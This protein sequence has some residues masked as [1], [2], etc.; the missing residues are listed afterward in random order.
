MPKIIRTTD[1]D[2]RIITG[3]NG[4]IILDTTNATND[5][6]GTVVI[7]GDLEVNGGT[8][9][10]ESTI[11]SIEDNIILLSSGNTGAGLPISLDR[12]RSSG[13]EVERGSL[14]NARW[15]Y[16]DSENWILGGLTGIGA[17]LG[18]QGDIGSEIFLPIKTPGILADGTLYVATGDGVISVTGTNNYELKIWNYVGGVITPDIVTGSITIDDDNIPNAKAVKDAIDYSI[19]TITID[20]IIEDNSKIE[21]IDKNN[22]ISSILEVGSRTILATGSSNHGYSV[23]DSI[24]ISGVTSSPNDSI[25]N[26]LNGTWTVTDVPASNIIEI[27]AP[28]TGGNKANYI[29]NS[30]KTIS[31]E[32]T[33][34]VTV[35]NSL[36]ANFY[37][38][39]INLAGIEFRDSEIFTTVSN[40]T[41]TLSAPGSGTVKIKD[42]LEIPKTPGDDDGLSDPNFPADGIKLYSKTSSTGKTGL[43]FVNEKNYRDEIISKNRALL[44]G[45]IF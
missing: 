44:Y 20:K 23:N 41:L 22:T 31:S 28:T 14:A 3:Q 9:T 21:V 45:M 12:P 39:R 7:K 5:R 40:E 4:T 35:E 25:I 1:T 26:S 8:T 37:N 13:I 17:W 34:A 6:S 16:D 43:F 27:N 30:G 11:T 42:T 29:S 18:T 33:I 10:V 19:A 24:V 38:N 36:I 32:S 2:Y 15:V